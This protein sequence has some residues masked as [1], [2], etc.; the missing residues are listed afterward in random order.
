VAVLAQPN[1]T[2]WVHQGYWRQAE[3]DVEQK[4]CKSA[5]LKDFPP[6]ENQGHLFIYDPVS[7]SRYNELKK[8][9]EKLPRCPQQTETARL[10]E[11]Y[12][13]I[14]EFGVA[15]GVSTTHRD[16][17]LNFLDV[18]SD[19]TAS[20][21]QSASGTFGTFGVIGTFVIPGVV[22]IPILPHTRGFFETGLVP[23][24][25][26]PSRFVHQFQRQ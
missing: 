14:L 26:S 6:V 2:V 11:E 25:Q 3:F 21:G 10:L 18:I 9:W 17:S 1:D 4:K 5:D 7:R 24:G 8:K 13:P 12:P 15:G 20:T 16:G 23:Y 19:E 22:P